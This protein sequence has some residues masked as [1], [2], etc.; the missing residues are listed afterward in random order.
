MA[1]ISLFIYKHSKNKKKTES[2][3]KKKDCTG[4]MKNKLQINLVDAVEQFKN[5]QC[6]VLVVGGIGHYKN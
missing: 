3:L 2:Q 1:C 5:C 4:S 6:F